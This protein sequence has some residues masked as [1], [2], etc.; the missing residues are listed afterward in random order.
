MPDIIAVQ[1]AAGFVILNNGG[2]VSGKR[3]PCKSFPLT[4]IPSI[5]AM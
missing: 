1:E 5:P 3:K 4:F 2:K